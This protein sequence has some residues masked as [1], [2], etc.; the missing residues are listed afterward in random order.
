MDNINL[1][2]NQNL[3]NLN[4]PK[5]SS[6]KR[7]LTLVV[8]LGVLAI[9]SATF[10]WWLNKEA[11]P[12]VQTLPEKKDEVVVKPVAKTELPANFPTDLPLEKDAKVLQ[13]NNS[14]LP[15]NSTEVAMREYESAKT[16]TQNEKIF[17]DYL[18]NSGYTATS[19]EKNE[20]EGIVALQGE[21]NGYKLFINI[22]TQAKKI[23]VFISN[24]KM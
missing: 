9:A 18:N 1:S 19:T 16:L 13:N 6:N 21:K 20:K 14:V 15:P 4:L 24:V 17:T 10:Y 8:I 5:I 7:I 11:E 3:N 2:Q 22:R 23:I 12:V